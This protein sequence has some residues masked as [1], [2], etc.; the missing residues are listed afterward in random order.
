MDG[1]DI[2][3]DCDVASWFLLWGIDETFCE[4]YLRV[5]LVIRDVCGRNRLAKLRGDGHSQ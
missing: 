1:W 2:Y 4:A 3:L 5:V